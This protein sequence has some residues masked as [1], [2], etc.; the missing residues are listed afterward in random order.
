MSTKSTSPHAESI[1]DEGLQANAARIVATR[2]RTSAELAKRGF[3]VVPSA[4]NFLFVE[5]PA[6]RMAADLFADLRRQKILVRYFPGERTGRYLRGSIG[7]DA[8]MD[9]FLA[10]L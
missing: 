6:G 10:A 3:R 2:E 9:A 7:T 1:R 8:E 4:A 5:P